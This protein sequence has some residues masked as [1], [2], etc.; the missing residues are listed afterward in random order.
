[1]V[2]RL[3][4]PVPWEELVEAVVSVVAR[5]QPMTGC[6]TISIQTLII[7]LRQS[8]HLLDASMIEIKAVTEL[9]VAEGRIVESFDA[10]GRRFS[11]PKAS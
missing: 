11:L 6:P 7:R 1:M 4:A 5:Q 8:P 3:P 9:L 10:G 2:M